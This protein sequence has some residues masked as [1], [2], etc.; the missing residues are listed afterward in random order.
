MNKYKLIADAAI[1]MNL[2]F[3]IIALTCTAI[4]SRKYTKAAFK[5]LFHSIQEIL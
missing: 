1:I 2:I 3:I 5:E 4:Y